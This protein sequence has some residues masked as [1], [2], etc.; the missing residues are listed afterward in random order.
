MVRT[1]RQANPDMDN[2]D[3]KKLKGR[4]LTEARVRTGAKKNQIYITD[5]EWEAIQ[6]GA[7]SPSALK[8]ILNNADQ[9]RVKEL[10]TP[11]SNKLMNTSNVSRAKQMLDNGYTQAEVADALGVSVSTLKRALA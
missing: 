11:R 5:K 7:I 9:D 3:I 8:Q 4:C 1:A 10:S 6:A 2:D